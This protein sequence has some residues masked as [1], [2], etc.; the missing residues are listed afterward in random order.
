MVARDAWRH[1]SGEGAGERRAVPDGTVTLIRINPDAPECPALEGS[2]VRVVS[3]RATALEAIDAI[4][5]AMR[6]QEE[7][8]TEPAGEG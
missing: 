2:G 1:A 7:A 4:E 6:S 5:A 8:G 3:L